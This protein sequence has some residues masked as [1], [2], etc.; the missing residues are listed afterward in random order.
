MAIDCTFE[1]FF[2]ILLACGVLAALALNLK[3]D[4]RFHVVVKSTPALLK[5]QLLTV[6]W[7][8]DVLVVCIFNDLRT[9]DNCALKIF[10]AKFHFSEILDLR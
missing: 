7:S 6:N 2:V 1:T 5:I 10:F 4:Q 8:H 9:S 3:L